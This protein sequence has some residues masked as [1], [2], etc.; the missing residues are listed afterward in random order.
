[1]KV[2]AS[3][4]GLSR[5]FYLPN[6]DAAVVRGAL[7]LCPRA[8][9][10][11]LFVGGSGLLLLDASSELEG[12]RPTYVD[13]APF[14]VAYFRQVLAALEEAA[15]PADL[16][17]WYVDRVHPELAAHYARR[18]QTYRPEQALA[19]LHDLFH[20]RLFFEAEAL[21]RARVVGRA[22]A[23]RESEVAGYLRAPGEPH[24]FI[25]L[26][27]APDYLG[28]PDLDGL[29]AACRRH[30]APVYLLETSACLDPGAL[31][32]AWARAGYH[33]HPGSA[34]LDLRNRGLGSRTLERSWNRPGQV[35]FLVMGDGPAARAPGGDPR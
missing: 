21:A 32:A 14:Q 10:R 9:E 19:A 22:T 13:I 6:E 12:A 16:R 3:E 5:R 15:E 24:D 23:I 29:F 25:Y 35:E 17:R 2:A 11:P 8:P 4:W 33:L 34:E 18:G 20:I 26:G 1:M 7:G 31:R 28:A 27:N 30:G